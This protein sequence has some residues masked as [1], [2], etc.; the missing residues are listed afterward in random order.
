M[1]HMMRCLKKVQK[2]VQPQM[3][4]D[5]RLEGRHFDKIGSLIAR[6]LHSERLRQNP[7]LQ[8]RVVMLD[9]QAV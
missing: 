4:P 3:V 7:A 2:H 8:A 1:G 6:R 9:D 5:L